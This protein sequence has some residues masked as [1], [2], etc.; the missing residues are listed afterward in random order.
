MQNVEIWLFCVHFVYDFFIL[1][2]NN[3]FLFYCNCGMRWPCL[4]QHLLV[5]NFTVQREAVKWCF[6]GRAVTCSLFNIHGG[7]F[8]PT[9][10]LSFGLKHKKMSRSPWA[11]SLTGRLSPTQ[12]QSEERGRRISS[13][14]EHKKM[15]PVPGGKLH[16]YFPAGAA[17]AAAAAVAHV[18]EQHHQEVDQR[19]CKQMNI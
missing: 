5:L 12:N 2:N 18:G 4:P 7:S 15:E 3:I 11:K 13:C 1:N 8:Q 6:T 9:A 10:K 19:Y 14:Y 17:A 16:R